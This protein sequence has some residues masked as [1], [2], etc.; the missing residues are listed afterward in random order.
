MYPLMNCDP[1]GPVA[2]P[3]APS[4][5]GPPLDWTEAKSSPRYQCCHEQHHAQQPVK[6]AG[7]DDGIGH[8]VLMNRLD[9]ETH[10]RQ[11]RHCE[12]SSVE[13][14]PYELEVLARFKVGLL[15]VDDPA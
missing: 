14:Y 2:G 13:L 7:C 12:L 9:S 15:V 11:R 6:V 8:P 10:L 1:V 4:C 5:G 3:L